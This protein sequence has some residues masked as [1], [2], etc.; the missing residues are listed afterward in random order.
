MALL[1]PLQ[2]ALHCGVENFRKIKTV[3]RMRP[4]NFLHVGEASYI[5]S[6]C[7]PAVSV[8]PS[9]HLNLGPWSG[10][11]TSTLPDECVSSMQCFVLL[12][13]QVLEY[14]REYKK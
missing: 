2:Y 10:A 13:Y 9:L 6:G 4:F 5:V 3:K 8:C 7:D 11:A 12:Q 14:S 1:D